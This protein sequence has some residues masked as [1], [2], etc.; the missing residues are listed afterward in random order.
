[1]T[2]PNRINVVLMIAAIGGATSIWM[3]QDRKAERLRSENK[4]LHRQLDRLIPLESENV[5]LSNIVAEAE[6]SRSNR[7]LL[8][9][10]RLR[11]EVG[12]LRRQTNEL[13][14]LQ[15]QIER[16]KSLAAANAP[17]GTL[18]TNA[19]TQPLAV[20]P[21]EAWG[22]V[23]YDTPE[24]AFQTLNWAALNGDLSTIR[25]ALTAEMQQDFDTAIQNITASGF[26]NQIKAE[27]NDK[28]EVRILSKYEATDHLIILEVADG[29]SPSGEQGSRDKLVYQYIDGQWKLAADH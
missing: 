20:Y 25:A 29:K 3:V 12:M 24:K 22:N 13:H 26:A 1:M 4:L 9:L 8:D 17:A 23:G 14:E 6:A 21:K 16:L 18:N 11:N 5:R 2:A 28:S 27:F 19:P 15:E 7:Q 10:L